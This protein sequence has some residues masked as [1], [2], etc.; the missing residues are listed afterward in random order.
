MSAARRQIGIVAALLGMVPLACSEGEGA[1]SADASVP[2]SAT[3]AGAPTEASS[4]PNGATCGGGARASAQLDA[5]PAATQSG[6]EAGAA[7]RIAGTATFATTPSGVDLSVSITGCVSGSAY[8]VII[9]EG[10]ACTSA[11]L[12][13]PDWD[14]PRGDGI[15]G[16][17]CT[18]TSGIGLLYYAR[19]STDPKPWSVGGP[20]SSAV[21]GHV[22]VIHDP[23]TMEPLA[24]G[25]IVQAPDDGGLASDAPSS[26]PGAVPSAMI[27][28]QIAGLCLY[29]M[30]S[31]TEQCPDPEK[32]SDCACTHCG[33]SSCLGQ[34]S[35]YA[36]CLEADLD[37][38]CASSCVI[39]PACAACG[40][41]MLRC[42]L[43]FCPDAVGCA[44]PTPGG[45][46]S[47]VEACCAKQGSRAQQCLAAVR[48]IETLGG[49]PSCIGTMHDWDFLTNEAYDPPC[50][51]DD[52]GQDGGTTDAAE[53]SA[54]D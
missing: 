41:D 53:A 7:R 39:D 6:T 18:G 42:L 38:G 22:L 31:P 2:A 27:R 43:A 25:A 3:E 52:A 51:F 49:D 11:M 32:L 16:L 36:S 33:L 45:P 10:D 21:T 14:A 34:C 1:K 8:P 12:Q 28:A 37:A 35:N 46:C 20:A 54:R 13:G 47:Q 44:V 4:P 24:C 40:N 48:Q 9:H 17:T 29:R 23:A 26:N 30:I 50:N 5:L 19:P 15:P